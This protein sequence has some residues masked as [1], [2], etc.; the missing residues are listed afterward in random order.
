MEP[1]ELTQS[2]I[3]EL[4]SAVRSSVDDSPIVKS[5]LDQLHFL[6][7]VPDMTLKMDVTLNR[8]MLDGLTDT[9]VRLA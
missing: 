9:R 4:V 2:A 3:Q 8:P 7:Y 5:A 6:G 1:D